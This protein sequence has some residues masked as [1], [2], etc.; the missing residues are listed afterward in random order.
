MR[1]DWTTISISKKNAEKLLSLAKIL[2]K[3][4][5]DEAISALLIG[6]DKNEN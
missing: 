4:T 5:Y 3:K 2:G 6:V 1:D